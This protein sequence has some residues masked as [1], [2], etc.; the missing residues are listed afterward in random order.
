MTSRSKEVASTMLSEEHSLKKLQEDDCWNLFTSHAF[1][2]DD[3]E[4]S[5]ECREIVKR[6]KGLP[7]ALKAMGSLL[8]NKSSV[9][10][11]EIVLKNEIWEFSKACFSIELHPPSFPS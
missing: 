2:G 10:E 5:P 6:C 4:P 7:L 3:T 9:S 1:R 8:Y 11:W